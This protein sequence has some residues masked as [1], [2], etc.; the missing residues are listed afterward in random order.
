MKQITAKTKLISIITFLVVI[1]FVSH[2]QCEIKAFASSKIICT[3][4]TIALWAKG[5]CG[6]RFSCDFDNNSICA[7]MITSGTPLFNNPCGASV[8]SSTYLWMGS[9]TAAPRYVRTPAVNVTSGGC[10]VCFDMKYGVNGQAAP[11][12][13]PDGA[14]EGVRLQY[15]TNGG[16]TY[17][18][19]QYWNPNGGND[20]TL[21]H[22]KNYCVSLPLAAQTANTIF[23][24]AQTAVLPAN[25]GHWGLD[26]IMIHCS[27]S[28]SITWSH[29]PS[30]V[31]PHQ[32]NPSNTTTYVVTINDVF[33]S[34]SAKDSIEVV[35]KIRPNA[36]FTVTTPVCENENS[37]IT[38]IGNA[39][40]TASYNWDFVGGIITS[41]SGQ[42]PY[43]VK[44]NSPGGYD[45]GLTV[46][47]NGCTSYLEQNEVLV[48]PL[49]SFFVDATNGCQ[50]LTINF[51]DN[52]TP[53]GKTYLWD[54]GDGTT[55]S[56]QSPSHTYNSPGKF[57]ISITI[58]TDSG[59]IGT[60]SIANLI[61]VHPRPDADFDAIPYI[62]PL[63]NP[64][65]EFKDKSTHGYT[66]LWDFGDG[67]S[68]TNQ[69]PNHTYGEGKFPVYLLVVSDHNCRDS[70]TKEVEI[71]DDRL[72]IPNVFTPNDDGINDYF[73]IDN[74][75]SLTECK[76]IVF[77]RWGQIVY[78]SKK[79]D[80]SWD[81]DLLSDGVY[82][83][84]MRYKGFFDENEIHGTI[85]IFRK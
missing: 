46:T 4:D 27:A 32:V 71:I 49:I 64:I 47:Q 31:G 62:A 45:V 59:C 30:G 12:E 85:T 5:F 74:I 52:T 56:A 18:D 15:S 16:T 78:Q 7:G 75:E 68:S 42:G 63:S 28:T 29:G 17:T 34:Y 19:I 72:T 69:N 41:G 43:L 26:N 11:C 55:S 21:T 58:E 51:L 80:N 8:D 2:S 36:D 38:Y 40:P 79:Y 77:N 50:P 25:S 14:N 57:G 70:I 82:F 10:Q 3:G 73:I 48:A 84:V 66:W 9:N 67:G 37:N 6:V 54:F 23:R 65:I 1:P 20:S 61:D 39:S 60:Y 13:G 76:L 33:S 24:W 44:W 83:F 81:G 22:W 35:V 53:V